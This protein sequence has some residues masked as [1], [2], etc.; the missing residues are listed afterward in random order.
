LFWKK[1]KTTDEL[2]SLESTEKRS[3]FRIA[4]PVNRPIHTVFKGQSVSVA[5]I[6]AMGLSFHL[7]AVKVGDIDQ[8]EFTLSGEKKAV[9]VQTEVIAINNNGVCHCRFL[10]LDEASF[11]A[12][13][14]YLLRVQLEKKR[15]FSSSTTSI[16][17]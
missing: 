3:S 7:D 10:N 2:F 12:V 16:I 17:S 9:S 11:D 1:K 5:T 8:I 13:H 14:R 15:A 6:G 4:P